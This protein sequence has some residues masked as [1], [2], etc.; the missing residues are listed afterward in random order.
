VLDSTVPMNAEKSAFCGLGIFNSGGW[1]GHTGIIFGYQTAVFYLPQTHTTLA[2]FTTTDVPHEVGTTLARAITRVIPP[3]T[4]TDMVAPRCLADR[5]ATNAVDE[6]DGIEY[7]GLPVSVRYAV[8][9]SNT[10][11]D[12]CP[13]SAY[14]ADPHITWRFSVCLLCLRRV[15]D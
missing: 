7:A 9:Q 1:I 3:T 8:R 13:V 5:T 15:G 4:S 12:H 6:Y 2:F 14:Q 11:R 10:A